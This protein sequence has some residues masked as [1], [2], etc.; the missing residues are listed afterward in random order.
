MLRCRASGSVHCHATA[1][2]DGFSAP[3]MTAPLLGVMARHTIELA[4]VLARSAV[5]WLTTASTK[6][7]ASAR[8]GLDY[9]EWLVP[10]NDRRDSIPCSSSGKK[11]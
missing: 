2:F 3:L 1:G 10:L 7:R 11:D 8:E 9:G 6:A 4:S 5:G